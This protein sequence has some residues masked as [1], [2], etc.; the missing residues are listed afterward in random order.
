MADQGEWAP[1]VLTVCEPMPVV[2]GDVMLPAP[3]TQIHVALTDSLMATI[4]R[5]L[6]SYGATSWSFSVE[7]GRAAPVIVRE[8]RE[9]KTA[10]I[11]LGLGRHGK[12]A[13]LF[14]AETASRV[15]RHADVPVL[16]VHPSARA[17]PK[18]ALVALDF[19]HSSI[20]A[21]REAL[22]LLQRPGR[23]HLVH[24]K[25]SYN[26][27]A[28]ADSEWERA[29]A[30]GAEHEFAR[31]RGELGVHPGVEITS[32]LLTGGVI[33]KVLQAAKSVGADLIALGSRNQNVLDRLMIGSTPAQILRAAP[34][35]VLVAPPPDAVAL[36]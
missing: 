4:R 30:A 22:A 10:L 23:L 7:F 13:R 34:C 16:A 9:R 32:E 26:M 25:W 19:G 20:R 35:S 31:V 12:L 11:A 6:R 36:T 29:Y 3:P 33:E 28:F 14:G 5:Q 2:V 18:V 1:D 21:A 15:A 8:A 24:V 17:L 27:T